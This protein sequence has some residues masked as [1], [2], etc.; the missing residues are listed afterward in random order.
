[1]SADHPLALVPAHAWR[2]PP[3]MA[4]VATAALAGLSVA[5]ATPK[6]A[7]NHGMPPGR[8]RHMF[9][10]LDADASGTLTIDELKIGFA[11]E[12]KVDA[13]APHVRA[14]GDRT[15]PRARAAPHTRMRPLSV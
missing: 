5:E 7:A 13:L 2:S 11:K 10:K 15:D 4:E 6:A 9:K 8:V 14:A 3:S 12:F 1:M